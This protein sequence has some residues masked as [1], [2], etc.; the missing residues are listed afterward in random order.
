MWCEGKCF[1]KICHVLSL[2]V[3]SHWHCH[4]FE[5]ESVK[6]LCSLTSLKNVGL[7]LKKKNDQDRKIHRSIFLEH[8]KND[9]ETDPAAC[10]V[11]VFYNSD[12]NLQ[13][14][15]AAGRGQCH[16]LDLPVQWEQRCEYF[17]SE[18]QFSNLWSRVRDSDN[19]SHPEKSKRKGQQQ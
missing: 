5:D 16:T 1:L 19:T 15:G 4:N 13:D 17:L 11:S 2:S 7:F 3:T 12:L 8:P 18:L 9:R 6:Y 10:Y 14:Q